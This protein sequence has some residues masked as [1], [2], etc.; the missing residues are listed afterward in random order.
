ME[1]EWAHQFLVCIDDVNVLGPNTNTIETQKF[2]STVV[3]KLV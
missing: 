2:C 1:I 3:R